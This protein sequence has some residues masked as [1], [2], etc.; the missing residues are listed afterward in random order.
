MPLP[1]TQRIL[2]QA[3]ELG[4]ALAG[5]PHVRAWHEASRA[6]QE[7][8]QARQLLEDY[9]RQIEHIRKL[10]AEI[11]PVEVADKRKLADLQ[12]QVAGHELIKRMMA[13]E[14]DYVTLLRQVNQT[15]AAAMG[16]APAPAAGA[17][18]PAGQTDTKG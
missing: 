14:A 12:A 13:A 7:D 2:E 17:G 16:P 3:R 15:I 11:K 18:S 6:V 5:H 10:E 8:S 1:E 9:H 4:R